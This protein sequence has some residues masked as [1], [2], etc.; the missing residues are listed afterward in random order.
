MIKIQDWNRS[1]GEHFRY[2]PLLVMVKNVENRHQK[3]QKILSIRLLILME[4]DNYP[5]MPGNINAYVAIRLKSAHNDCGASLLV[6]V[7]FTWVSS[8]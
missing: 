4:A 3:R 7:Y 6:A 1:E 2:S 5:P 8:S